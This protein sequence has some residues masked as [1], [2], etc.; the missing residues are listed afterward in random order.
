MAHLVIAD[1]GIG[2]SPQAI[3][4]DGHEGVGLSGMRSRLEEIGGRLS[5]SKLV[6]GTAICASVP[7]RQ[8]I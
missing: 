5:L 2:I 3:A 8:E 6:R 1:D 7:I 4:K